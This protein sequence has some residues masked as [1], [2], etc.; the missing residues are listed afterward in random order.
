VAGFTSLLRNNPNYRYTWMGQVVSEVGDH[1]NTVAVMSLA[2]HLT[3]SGLAVGG[4]ML[5][6]TIP[7]ILA[8]PMSGVVLDRFDRRKIMIASDLA[9]SV[10]ALGFV[11]ILMYRQQWLLYALSGALAFASP[12]FTSGRSAIL[13]RITTA[14]E[15]HTANALTQ[16][17]AWLTLSIGAMLGGLSTNQFG[18]QWAFVANALSF[19]FSAW[20]VWNL[21]GRFLPDREHMT[22]HSAAAYWQ[23]FRESIAYMRATPL[24]LGIALSYV[25]WASGGGAAQ[26]LF[27]MYGEVVFKQGPFGLGLIWACAGFGLVGGG[28]L[29]H[30]LGNGLGFRQ[31]KRAISV[32]YFIHGLS[33]VLFAVMPTI[34]LSSL[35]IALSRVGMGSVN[36]LN[37]TMLLTHVPDRF[38]GRIFSTTDMILNAAMMVSLM[39]AS[40]ATDHV[41]IRTIGVIAGCLSGSTAFF[42]FWANAAGKLPEPTAVDGDTVGDY[43]SPVTRA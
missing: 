24:V 13:P 37:R 34:W 15:L 23:D 12:F 19:V 18:Y 43:E 9:R 32:G 22:P 3:G 21:K 27:T 26:M 30:R 14:E 6:R 10:I 7:A 40:V 4:T 28:I 20:A 42:W 29:A 8:G 36:V 31:Y 2:L 38:R 39:A 41:P 1:F 25:G 5:A 11:L 17:T 35:F 16:T 33:Y